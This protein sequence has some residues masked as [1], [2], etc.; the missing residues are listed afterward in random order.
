M[1]G[2]SVEG[3]G[4]DLLRELLAE[5]GSILQRTSPHI[6]ESMVPGLSRDEIVG[7][8]ENVDLPAPE[9][10][11]V[12]WTW[13]NGHIPMVPHGLSL[14]QNSLQR[15]LDLRWEDEGMEPAM[16]PG[17]D[18]I[19]VTG[20]GFRHTIATRCVDTD[21]PLLVRYCDPELNIEFG[22]VPDGCVLSLSTVMTWRLVAMREGWY[23]YD[24]SRGFWGWVDYGSVPA[25]WRKT[26]AL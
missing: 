25:E 26:L 24:P 23:R 10:L 9:E 18:W 14:Q 11:I 6:W 19:R 21:G 12:W 16:V 22:P 3:A 7:A 13:R 1:N 17:M 8:L 4:P 5:Y 2:L 15:S 20:D